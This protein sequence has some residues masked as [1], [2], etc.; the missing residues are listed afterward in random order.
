MK[1]LILTSSI[2]LFSFANSF[3]STV[4]ICVSPT[5]KKYHYSQK[6]RGLQ[7]CTHTIKSVTLS[8]ASK[9]G[10]TACLMEK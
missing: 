4:Y 1:N 10:Y 6:C 2:T 7:K 8:E 3:Q 5:A 9:L